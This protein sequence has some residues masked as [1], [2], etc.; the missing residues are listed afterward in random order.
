MQAVLKESL[1]FKHLIAWCLVLSIALHAAVMFGIATPVPRPAP[2]KKEEIRVELVKQEPPAPQPPVPEPPKPVPPPPQPVPQKPLPKEIKPS[3]VPQ[4]Q[5]PVSP[6]PPPTVIPQPVVEPTP[7]VIA[8]KPSPSESKP[9]VVV[10]PPPPPE[11][12]RPTG[13]S[14]GDIQAALNALRNAAQQELKK[15]HRYP[16]LALERGIEGVVKLKIFL[17]GHGNITDVE[18]LESSGNQTLDSSAIAAA[19]KAA[20]KPH[21]QDILKDHVDSIVV[22]FTFTIAR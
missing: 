7:A 8:V 14:E 20:L 17:D 4:K 6:E 22:P 11:P 19:K 10:I 9:E 1:Q 16:R 21:F 12:Q 18:I 3:P 15:H 2:A 5:T 13:P